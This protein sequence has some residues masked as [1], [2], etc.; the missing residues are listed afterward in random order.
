MNQFETSRL[1]PELLTLVSRDSKHQSV[2]VTAEGIPLFAK[3][4][5][6]ADGQ[7]QSEH[8]DRVAS[9]YLLNLTYPHTKAYLKY[10]DD[11]LFEA[12]GTENL[13]VTAEICCGHGEALNLMSGQLKFGVGADVSLN[14]L[15]SASKTLH[16]PKFAFIQA[17]A[18]ML[19]INDASVDTV[20]MFGGIHHVNDRAKLFSEVA[21]IL[22]PGGRFI[23]R[24]PISDFFLWKALRALIYRF[25]PALDHETERPLKYDET[26]P[27]LEQ[28]NLKLETW[29]TYG[30]IG[31][32][33]FMNSDVL[34]FNRLFRFV[35]LI[36]KIVT[37]VAKMDEWI[38]KTFAPR[39]LGL[40]VIGIAR[41]K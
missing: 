31:F 7:R 40:Q 36:E 17:D 37:A 35:P 15:R 14:M 32:C 26:A 25:S 4:F 2:E 20:L 23:F 33:I 39:T 41:K 3:Q 12:V 11:A 8:Y 5:C 30:F 18:T 29:R 28:A 27:Y 21:R 13:G 16:P 24:E 9:E 1:S 22:K 34:V 6:S 19:P 10:L 38:V